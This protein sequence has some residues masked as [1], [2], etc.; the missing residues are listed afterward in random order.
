MPQGCSALTTG[1]SFTLVSLTAMGTEGSTG[2]VQAATD[3]IRAIRGR[4][5]VNLMAQLRFRAGM[6]TGIMR[7]ASLANEKGAAPKGRPLMM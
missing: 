2:S 1:S 6:A 7:P 3:A 5:V 4:R